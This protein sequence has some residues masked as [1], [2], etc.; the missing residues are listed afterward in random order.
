[1][2]SF[3][4]PFTTLLFAL[5]AEAVEYTRAFV[6]RQEHQHGDRSESILAA[7]ATDK[8]P[9]P[10]EEVYSLEEV[11]RPPGSSYPSPSTFL[12]E[13]TRIF[14]KEMTPDPDWPNHMQEQ[15]AS[16]QS[17]STEGAASPDVQVEVNGAGDVVP[18][19][20]EAQAF[21]GVEAAAASPLPAARP[22]IVAWYRSEDCAKAW[23]S[24]VGDW[25]G[26]LTK[27]DVQCLFHLGEGARNP[28]R[29]LD[30]MIE[31]GYDFGEIMTGQD[32]TI[33]SITR[34]TSDFHGD[35]QRIL[36]NNHPNFLHGHHASRAGIAY[37][38]KWVTNENIAITDPT[39]RQKW[40]VMCFSRS[41]IVMRGTARKNIAAQAG[42]T[43]DKNFNVYINEGYLNEV[44]D[45]GAM[46]LITWRR[47]LTEPELW[48]SMQ[49]LNWRLKTGLQPAAQSAMVAWF[50][51]ENAN[52]VWPSSVG[53]WQGRVTK[54]TTDVKVEQKHKDYFGRTPGP[55]WTYLAGSTVCGYDFGEIMTPDFTICSVTRYLNKFNQAR[56]LSNN[57]PN[58]L[59]GHHHKRVG[60]A[61][62]STWVTAHPH[63]PEVGDTEWVVMCGNREGL[64][65]SGLDRT[66]KGKHPGVKYH[67]NFNLYINE[68]YLNEVSDWG[69]ME[70]I[71]WNR[72]LTEEEMWTSMV[73]LL[74]K[75][76][77]GNH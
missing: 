13:L 6:R 43:Y 64:V 77:I 71:T 42:G 24:S 29:F 25:E 12:E 39:E 50:K 7:F 14:G 19:Q 72:P 73:Y 26:R 35:Q 57:H 36:T 67:K 63:P 9:A 15:N 17:L 69:V 68:G 5:D 47:S 49:Y 32:Y 20:G 10:T 8:E 18:M 52:R 3:L 74:W 34:Y 76:H 75:V 2:I 44:S 22:D 31:S 4:V 48:H 58:F 33:C 30:G 27:G 62:Y 56:I 37:S 28:V 38:S 54:G 46:E 11:T 41:G 23:R 51:S 1:M 55:K 61:H 21:M 45:F 40:L 70:V 60:L 65:M 53:T 59:H 66:D 16:Q